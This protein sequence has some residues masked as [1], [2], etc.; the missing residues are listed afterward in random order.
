MDRILE[1]H[2]PWDEPGWSCCSDL[3]CQ[4]VARCRDSERLDAA[5][6]AW[7]TEREAAAG[8]C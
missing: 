4:F 3:A 2:G 8:E 1:Q 6:L 5:Y 7:R